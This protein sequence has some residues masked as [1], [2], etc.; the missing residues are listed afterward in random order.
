MPAGSR[1]G[2]SRSRRRSSLALGA[3]LLVLALQ[4][5]RARC[6]GTAASRF[7]AEMLLVLG[8]LFCIVAGYFAIA[9]DDGGGAARRGRPVV[10]RAARR[11]VGVLRRSRSLLVAALAWRLTGALTRAAATAAGPSS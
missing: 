9:A 7:S 8:A 1:R 5:A 6:A 2:C 4:L 10:R 11:R 3:L